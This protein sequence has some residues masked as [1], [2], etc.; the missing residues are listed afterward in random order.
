[1]AYFVDSIYRPSIFFEK[2]IFRKIDKFAIFFE[3]LLLTE[4]YL[5]LL[6]LNAL[7]KEDITHCIRMDF[8]PEKKE[9]Q[10]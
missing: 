4:V 5:Y 2:I 8:Y 9:Q 3:K 6:I 1:M 7:T 10:F